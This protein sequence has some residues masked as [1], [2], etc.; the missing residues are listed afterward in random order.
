MVAA[1]GVLP[2][3]LPQSLPSGSLSFTG[4]DL[5]GTLNVSAGDVSSPAVSL[6]R[7]GG[8]EFSATLQY[9]LRGPAGSVS[10]TLSCPS[11]PATSGSALS[12]TTPLSTVAP[13]ATADIRC[14]TGIIWYQATVTSG[15]RLSVRT[16]TL[17]KRSD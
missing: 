5:G 4:A 12:V 15:A 8:G 16:L 7:V 6:Q 13:S 3:V 14:P 1:F 11:S 9:L 17:S 2:A 10:F